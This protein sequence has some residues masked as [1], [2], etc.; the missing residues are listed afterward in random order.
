M[1][2]GDYLF[3]RYLDSEIIKSDVAASERVFEFL[4][5]NEEEEGEIVMKPD[6]T[7]IKG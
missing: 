1:N 6:H 3:G 2:W 7:V 5:E 4:S